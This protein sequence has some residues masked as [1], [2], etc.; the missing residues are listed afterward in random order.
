MNPTILSQATDDLKGRMISLILICQLAYK[1]E[2]LR[3]RIMADPARV[4][5]LGKYI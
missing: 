3:L 4:E 5:G 1:K 2:K